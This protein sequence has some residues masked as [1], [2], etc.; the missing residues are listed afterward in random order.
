[1]FDSIAFVLCIGIGWAKLPTE[2]GCGSGWTC[3]RRMR[4]WAEGQRAVCAQAVHGPTAETWDHERGIRTHR[5]RLTMGVVA[6]DDGD[7]MIKL[8]ASYSRKDEAAVRDLIADLGRAHLSVWHDQA[9]HGGDPWWQNILR[10]I[11]ECDVF[12]FALSKD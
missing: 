2:L 12:L 11:R 1:V 3:W 4:E 5:S 6:H 9:L 8:F 10:R 7:V